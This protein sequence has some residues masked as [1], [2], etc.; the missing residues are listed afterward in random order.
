MPW[1]SYIAVIPRFRAI[2]P[3]LI[4]CGVHLE[5]EPSAGALGEA[6]ALFAA[7][8]EMNLLAVAAHCCGRRVHNLSIVDDERKQ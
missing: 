2:S 7:V 1:S 4:D 6:V 3:V 5:L 8:D